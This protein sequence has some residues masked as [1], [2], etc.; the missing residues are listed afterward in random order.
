MLDTTGIK[1][2]TYARCGKRRF[3]SRKYAK[4]FMKKSNQ[5][6]GFDLTAV[7]YCE[8]CGAW[9]TTSMPK[10]NSRALGRHLVAPKSKPVGKFLNNMLI[11]RYKSIGK[12]AKANKV[13]AGTIK[14]AIKDELK[15]LGLSWK[16]VQ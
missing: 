7:Y 9:H 2:V 3:S 1:A 11:E 10:S 6:N 5:F 8:P 16:F 13:S 15:L 14:T 4:Q 12:A